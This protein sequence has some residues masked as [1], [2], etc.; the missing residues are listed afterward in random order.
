MLTV[1]GL[2]R[3]HRALRHDSADPAVRATTLLSRWAVSTI[4]DRIVNLASTRRG[5]HPD[6]PVYRFLLAQSLQVNGRYFEEAFEE[7]KQALELRPNPSI[8]EAYINVGNIF[9]TTGQYGGSRGQLPPG[10]W[11]ETPIP[12]WRYFNLHLAQSESFNFSARPRNRS[13]RRATSRLRPC[14]QP[15]V[16]DGSERMV[17]PSV[18]V[19]DATLHIAFDLGLGRGTGR[20]AVAA[21]SDKSQTQSADDLAGRLSSA[22]STLIALVSLLGLAACIALWASFGRTTRTGSPLHP[23]RHDRSAIHCKSSPARPRSTAASACTLFV[24]GDGLEPGSEV[25]RKL[26]EIERY[27]RRWHGVSV[28]KRCRS[29][30]PGAGAVASR[31]E[32]VGVSLLDR[33]AGSRRSSPSRPGL[34]C[35]RSASCSG[36][37]LQ[38][39]VFLIGA[40]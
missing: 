26:F 22:C 13:S 33:S 10:R 37:I 28:G 11:S 7:Y 3:D 23:L 4:P 40:G 2:Q 25:R 14:G 34:R 1:A 19:L 20:Q 38:A 39:S 9:Y 12:S 24:L 35:D 15:A 18:Q 29:L 8:S 5:M 6:D 32:R 27:E 16:V 30:L 36:P 17:R 31:Q 21:S